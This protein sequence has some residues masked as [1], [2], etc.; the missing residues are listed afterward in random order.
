[1][2]KLKWD[3]RH[4]CENGQSLE[5]S[6][7][8]R[9]CRRT[10]QEVYFGEP[11]GDHDS[12]AMEEG[13]LELSYKTKHSLSHMIQQLPSSVFT[14]RCWNLRPYKNPHTNI[15]RSIVHNWQNLEATKKPFQRW[16]NKQWYTQKEGDYSV[17]KKK[18]MCSQVTTTRGVGGGTW[19]KT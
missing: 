6:T 19:K 14:E 11:K 13:S 17:I 5:H 4:S 18:K 16:R 15:Y 8:I 3:P 2:C 9:S 7:T 1:M 12:T 10:G